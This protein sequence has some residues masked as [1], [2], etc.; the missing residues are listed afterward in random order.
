VDEC[1]QPAVES[2]ELFDGLHL[3]DGCDPVPDVG[4]D[5]EQQ[6]DAWDEQQQGKL[7]TQTYVMDD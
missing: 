1:R 2:G 3:P 4:A 5:E 7:G 6:T